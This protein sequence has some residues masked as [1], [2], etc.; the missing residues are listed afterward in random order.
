M[1]A[2][3]AAVVGRVETAGGGLGSDFGIVGASQATS[4]AEM[5]SVPSVD[6]FMPQSLWA[7]YHF[8]QW[9]FVSMLDEPEGFAELGLFAD[10]WGLLDD[11]PPA[12]RTHPRALRCRLLCATGLEKWELGA[13]LARIVGETG[14]PPEFREVA[15]RFHLARCRW[16]VAAGSIDAAKDCWRLLITCWPESRLALLND[17]TFGEM[18]RWNE[19]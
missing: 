2:T 1:P 17:G 13:D 8:N 3:G 19:V 11:L 5:V 16:L 7:C 12:L 9:F 15:G 14:N 10:A 18:L 6:N 4:A